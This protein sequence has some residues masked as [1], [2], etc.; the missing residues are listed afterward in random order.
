MASPIIQEDVAPARDVSIIIV[1]YNTADLLGPCLEAV[2]HQQGVN[3]EVLVVDNASTDDSAALV[4]RQYP[5]VKL[6]VNA[7]NRGFGAANNQ[8][9]PLCQG[10][11]ILYLNPDTV[12]A[13]ACLAVAVSYMDNHP[14]VG[15]AGL[16][17][18][19]PDGTDQPSIAYRYLNQRRTRGELAGLPG[20]IAAVLGAAMIARRDVV[21]A[22]EGFD[23]DFF[24]Y[25]EDEDLCLRIRR[26]GYQI[27][28]IPEAR[29]IHFHG[30]SE[31]GSQPTEVW[32]KKYRAEMQFYRKHYDPETIARIVRY[33]SWRT[34]WRMV[35]LKAL[36]YLGAN[37]EVAQAKFEKYAIYWNV[38]RGGHR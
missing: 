30:Q 14:E 33:E 3:L 36:T 1:S 31:R 38:L 22:V 17:I 29:V 18:L 26:R 19:N 34:L 21:K 13:D 24:L 16:H 4:A 5:Q 15:L 9:L 35:S 37:K 12:M 7:I 2:L 25:G 23:E 10:R 32:R 6:M 8:A 27:G 11:Y 28:F 20:K